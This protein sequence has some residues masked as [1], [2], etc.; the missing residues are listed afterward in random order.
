MNV[1]KK[2]PK[3]DIRTCIS[4]PV[5]FIVLEKF[6]LGYILFSGYGKIDDILEKYNKPND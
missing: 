3:D 2:F 1:N 6:F 5:I 4:I